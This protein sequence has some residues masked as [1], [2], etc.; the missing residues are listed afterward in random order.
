MT[1]PNQKLQQATK[2][3][4]EFGQTYFEY[5][6]MEIW[7]AQPSVFYYHPLGAFNGKK[8]YV[9]NTSL[10]VVLCEIDSRLNK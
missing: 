5:K 9:Y 3:T 8:T 2:R 7:E 4:T 10:D 6:G 1:T